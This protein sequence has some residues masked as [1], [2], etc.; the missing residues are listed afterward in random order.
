MTSRQRGYLEALG[1][2][3]FFS[4]TPIFTKWAYR[5]DVSPRELLTLR[6]MASVPVY[7]KL[8]GIQ[9]MFQVEFISI[10]CK[11]KNLLK[12]RR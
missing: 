5:Y 1:A 3:L 12:L 10:N 8:N 9:V 6:L 11:Q 4:I 7:T 2:S